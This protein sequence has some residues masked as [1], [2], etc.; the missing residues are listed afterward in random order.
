MQ[1]FP[2]IIHLFY[3]TRFYLS[4]L[5][6]PNIQLGLPIYLK[7]LILHQHMTKFPRVNQYLISH[8]LMDMLRSFRS[9]IWT[10][11]HLI[12]THGVLLS[13]GFV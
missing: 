9:S 7:F 12:T 8:N 11:V 1:L 5:F 10:G 2:P 6:I 3:L 13:V 4:Y